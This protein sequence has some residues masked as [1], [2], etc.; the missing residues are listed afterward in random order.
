MEEELSVKLCNNKHSL[1]L[2][3]HRFFATKTTNVILVSRVAQQ[4]GQLV[5]IAGD[6]RHGARNQ[7]PTHFV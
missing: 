2:Q 6:S 1:A 5:I 4:I 3:W 7:S